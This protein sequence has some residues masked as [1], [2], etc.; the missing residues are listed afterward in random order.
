MLSFLSLA[1]DNAV[2][3]VTSCFVATECFTDL[4]KLNLVRLK[5][6]IVAYFKLETIFDT[7]PAA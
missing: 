4:D 3:V 5:L 6:V 7:T 1:V 2:V